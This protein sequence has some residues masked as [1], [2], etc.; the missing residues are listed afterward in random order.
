MFKRLAESVAKGEEIARIYANA[1]NGVDEA[2]K[3][4]V[5]AINIGDSMPEPRVLIVERVVS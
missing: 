2:E 3:R 5:E 4:C 1:S